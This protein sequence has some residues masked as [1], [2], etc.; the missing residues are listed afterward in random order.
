MMDAVQA[1]LQNFAGYGTLKKL[2]LMVIAHK[3]TSQEIG[4]LNK[5]FGKY[6][7]NKNGIINM[8]E[9]K[10]A[11]APYGYTDDEIETTFQGIDLDG[12]GVVHYTE[13]LAASIEAHGK[14]NEERIAEA[15]DRLDCDDSGFITTKNLRDFLGESMPANYLDEIIDEADLVEDHRISYDEFLQLWSSD[16]DSQRQDSFHDVVA[17]R[18]RHCPSSQM[19]AGQTSS[20]HSNVKSTSTL[21]SPMHDLSENNSDLGLSFDEDYWTGQAMY[22]SEKAKSMRAYDM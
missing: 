5:I 4:F 10:A 19:S 18:M 13:F 2:G 3:S 6:D 15:F 16:D 9:F 21:G 22:Q 11:L 8:P 20:S 17:R 14:I 12:T 7:K 1:T